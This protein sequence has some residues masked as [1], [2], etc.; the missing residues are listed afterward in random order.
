MEQMQTKE[1][2]YKKRTKLPSDPNHPIYYHVFK[3]TLPTEACFR[4]TPPC[5]SI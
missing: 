1:K 4:G 3:D 5:K 2:Q